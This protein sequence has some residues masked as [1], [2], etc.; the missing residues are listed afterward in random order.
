MTE[1]ELR[2][3]NLCAQLAE[4]GIRP[5]RGGRS[6]LRLAV[7][8]QLSV[9][10]VAAVLGLAESTV[11]ARISRVRAKLRA[12]EDVHARG[13]VET[14][15]DPDEEGDPLLEE[16]RA[17]LEALRNRQGEGGPESPLGA[18]AVVSLADVLG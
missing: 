7:A 1:I 15:P 18:A 4:G 17:L 8:D 9:A 12:A 14:E 13:L 2:D 3:R 5:D 11:A 6:Y 10:E 16:A